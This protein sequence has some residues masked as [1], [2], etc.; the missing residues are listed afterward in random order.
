MGVSVIGSR[1]VEKSLCV[2]FNIPHYTSFSLT[3]SYQTVRSESGKKGFLNDFG[4]FLPSGGSVKVTVD[5]S[6]KYDI[7]TTASNGIVVISKRDNLVSVG[8]S[9]ILGVVDPG[10]GGT[11]AYLL[12]SLTGTFSEVSLGYSGSTA[13]FLT[14]S[15]LPDDLYFNTSLLIE[16][17]LTTGTG[18]GR[19]QLSGGSY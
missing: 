6:V 19:Y 2:P 8:N 7:T 16:A 4:F 10:A 14:V 3:S 13:I 1:V 12:T 17:K 15:V 18:T 9:A 5:G 11:Q